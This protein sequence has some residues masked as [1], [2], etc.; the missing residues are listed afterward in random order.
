MADEILPGQDQQAAAE[1]D[2]AFAEIAA[3]TA[4]E[5]PAQAA[6]GDEQPA[7][8]QHAPQEPEAPAEQPAGPPAGQPDEEELRKKAHGY[9]SM[10]GRLESV[11]AEN[12]A[13]KERLAQL[14]RAVAAPPSQAAP[15]EQPAVAVPEDIREDLEALTKR[16]PRLAA[17]ALEDSQDGARLRKAL[18]D[19][20][21]DYAEERADVVR[22]RRELDSKVAAVE[23][24]TQQAVRTNAV[25]TFYATIGAKHPDWV[26]LATDPQRSH[27]HEQYMHA[28]RAWAEAK[29]YAEGARLFAIM[30]QGTP[31]EVIELLDRY[32]SETRTSTQTRRSGADDAL[33]VPSRSAPPPAGTRV[34]KDDF[35]AAFAEAARA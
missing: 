30:N 4:P 31:T 33:A 9:D 21:V 19:Y 16:D 12:K 10:F 3:D 13:L 22:L 24:T 7:Q 1:F 14:E 8:T 2:A 27:E 28:V 34:G 32:K 15:A 5:A 25:Q 35:D 11:R 20:G 26:S 29:P 23:S 6:P 17:L 18:A